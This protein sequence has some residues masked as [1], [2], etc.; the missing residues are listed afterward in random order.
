VTDQQK[1]EFALKQA[2]TILAPARLDLLKLAL[3][4]RAH[5]PAVQLHQQV[6]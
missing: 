1:Y 6:L 2:A 5:S 4:I 3:S